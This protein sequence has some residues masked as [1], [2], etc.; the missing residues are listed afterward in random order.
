MFVWFRMEHLHLHIWVRS[1]KKIEIAW[2]WI[3]RLKLKHKNYN[4]EFVHMN[5]C[6]SLEQTFL[7]LVRSESKEPISEFGVDLLY[8]ILNKQ[9]YN[10]WKKMH[11]FLSWNYKLLLL[12]ESVHISKKREDPHEK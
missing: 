2:Y 6:H 7:L 4:H 1:K 8:L 12:P 11:N 3:N 10:N 9:L 5:I